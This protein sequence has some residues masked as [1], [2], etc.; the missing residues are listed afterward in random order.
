MPLPVPGLDSSVT[1]PPTGPSAP[2]T[3]PQP[4]LE[5]QA[6]LKVRQAAMLLADAV[7]LLKDKLGSDLGKAVMGAL[8]SLQPYIPGADSGLGQSE[9]A[10]MMQ[11]VMPV[12]PSPGGAMPPSPMGFRSPRPV[13]MG[14]GPRIGGGPPPS[15]ATPPGPPM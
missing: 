13:T 14:G 6:M 15:G 5:S 10:S 2:T 8:K 11:Q 3:G 1:T 9:L 7:P 12:R 4:G